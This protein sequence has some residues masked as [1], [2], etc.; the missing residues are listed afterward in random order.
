MTHKRFL[1]SDGC[2]VR[3]TRLPVSTV[4]V[5]LTV[6]AIAREKRIMK[7]VVPSRGTLFGAALLT[8]GLVT[9]A[10][11]IHALSLTPD[12][13]SKS[14]NT[15]YDRFR[16]DCPADTSAIRRY[17]SSLFDNKDDR[18]SDAIW[19]AV[20]R[21]SNNAPSVYVK[22]EFLQAMRAAVDPVETVSSFQIDDEAVQN[23]FDSSP[24][25]SS[26]QAPVAVACLRPSA[27]FDDCWVLD[28]MR[29]VLKK[30]NWDASCDGGSE[31]TE[32]IAAA[33]DSLLAQYLAKAVSEGRRFDGVIRTKG[34]LVG[35]TLLEKRGFKEVTKLEKDMATHVS[36]LDAC[37]ERYA[38][39][40]VDIDTKSPGAR[41]RA[42][43]IV[44]YLGRLD[45]EQDL[46]ASRD[47]TGTDD[48]EEDDFDPWAG[49]K[50]F[51]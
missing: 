4:R 16:V 21:T 10:I 24:S 49:V 41:Q 28:S 6:S 50:R 23:A 35:G 51:L 47:A 17:S 26:Q 9:P 33:I 7:T 34:T 43:T 27:H 42:L 11:N 22:D 18:D 3:W 45:R 14:I 46:K 48:G 25:S 29:C 44:S 36:S 38:E 2:E 12:G 30:E 19:A 37:M 8:M 13:S 31:H 40:S 32:A 15:L 20:F 39:R 5:V 1:H